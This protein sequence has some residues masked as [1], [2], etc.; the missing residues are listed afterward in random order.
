MPRGNVKSFEV[1]KD[2]FDPK[3]MLDEQNWYNH[4][5]GKPDVLSRRI[6]WLLGK[7]LYPMYSMMYGDRFLDGQFK[8]SPNLKLLNDPQFDYPVMS[9]TDKAAILAVAPSSTADVGKNNAEFE[10]TFT[11]NWF[12]INYLIESP[13]QSQVFI[14]DHGKEGPNGYVYTLQINGTA[15]EVIHPSDLVAGTLWCDLATVNAQSESRGT[16]FKRVMP[17]KYKNQMNVIRLSHS[18][19]GNVTKNVMNIE[20]VNKNGKASKSWMGWELY[21]F[22][23]RWMKDIEHLIWY[24]RYNVRQDGSVALKDPLTSKVIRTG[25]GLLDQIPNVDTYSRLTYN[26]LKRVL[27]NAYFGQTDTDGMEITLWTGTG[28]MD[29]FDRAMKEH[30]IDQIQSFEGIGE[31]FVTG[32]FGKDLGLGGFF[33]HAYFIDG[34][35]VKVKKNPL[36]DL[37]RRA[38]ISPKHPESG[39]P[40]ESYRMVF[41]DDGTFD[42]EP[43]LQFVAEK[44]RVFN[45][46]VVR[47]LSE[48]PAEYR[49]VGNLEGGALQLLSDDVDKASYHRLSTCGV[50]LK[51][52]NTSINLECIMG[53]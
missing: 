28:G 34:Y 30:G 33:N 6:T 21:Q 10:L 17:G 22:E 48:V 5:Q 42:G 25:A 29:E 20:I 51:R 1:Q 19:A 15:S 23:H 35:M 43:N 39:L 12:K 16:E 27:R 41:I 18:W 49:A 53:L 47:G 4:R 36:F 46:G 32:S 50:Q 24:S 14:R 52:A 26:K 37:G 7:D 44:G 2:I 11:D 3:S 31:K 13:L 8:G 40:L 45:H 9:R 38:Q